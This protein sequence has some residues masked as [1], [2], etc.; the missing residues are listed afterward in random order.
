MPP[1][2]LESYLRRI[3]LSSTDLT[4]E[5]NESLLRKVAA[6]QLARVPFEN[7][8][9]HR[10]SPVEVSVAAIEDKLLGRGRGGICY[11][12]NGLLARA[13]RTLGFDTHL[14]GAGVHTPDGLGLPLGHVAI[15]AT[16]AAGRWLVD[17]GFGGDAIVAPIDDN[18]AD[19]RDVSF[20]SGTSYRTDGVARPLADFAAMAW[21]HS[22][23]PQARFT[24]GIV[25][26][27]TSG[28]VRKTLSCKGGEPYRLT[29]VD[30]SLRTAEECDDIE[31]LAVLAREFGVVLPELPRPGRF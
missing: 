2:V 4:P 11:E 10:G 28:S 20:P 15:V 21:W 14:V 25:C 7:L 22:T 5:L 16:A 8:D 30:G 27:L 13:L 31:A 9:I 3:G 29:I 23:S 18:V 17:V 6:A 26:T 19:C 24:S 12:L 1:A